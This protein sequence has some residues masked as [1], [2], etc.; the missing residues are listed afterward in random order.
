MLVVALAGFAA[1]FVDGALGM[2]FGP[3]SSSILLSSGLSPAAVSATVNIAKVATGIVSGASHWRFG[4]VDRRLAIRL[5]IPGA[6]GAL[7]GT[8]ILTSVDGDQLRPILAVLLFLI[9]V[10]ILVRFRRPV[11]ERRHPDGSIDTTAR[12]AEIAGGVGGVTN[13]LIGAWGPV[14][15]PFLL[16]RGIVPRLVV[17]TVNTAEVA[18]AMVAVGSL[19]SS[20]QHGLDASTVVA[21]LVGGVLAAPVAALSVRH[22]PA[23]LLGVLVAGVLMLTNARELATWAELGPVRWVGYG[24]IVFVVALA[25]LPVMPGRLPTARAG[26]D[27]QAEHGLRL[28]IDSAS[29]E[30]QLG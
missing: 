1:S 9:G 5:A 6:L 11:E 25:A 7:I 23:R 26:S 2:G 18:V 4:N 19:L 14:V 3:T 8:T 10:R 22:V 20:T 15:T 28:G 12:G 27:D 17:G 13:G 30:P 29:G 24:V 16:H 21:M